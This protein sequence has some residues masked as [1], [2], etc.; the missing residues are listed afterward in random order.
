MM[1]LFPSSGASIQPKPLS[2]TTSVGAPLL[3][4][5]LSAD[6]ASASPDG[7]THA[8]GASE[9]MIE[10]QTR[11]ELCTDSSCARVV[12]PQCRPSRVAHQPVAHGAPAMTHSERS[13]TSHETGRPM[14]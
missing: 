6:V 12:Q 11:N 5:R 2:D 10:M 14:V 3:D 8:A 13:A 1:L 7:E 9:I 4:G